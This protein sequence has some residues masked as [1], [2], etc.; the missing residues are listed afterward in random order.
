MLTILSLAII[1]LLIGII[2]Q[3]KKQSEYI[4]SLQDDILKLEQEISALKLNKKAATKRAQTK[5]PTKSKT[6]EKK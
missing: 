6:K 1:L 2:F 5:K 4:T 3:I